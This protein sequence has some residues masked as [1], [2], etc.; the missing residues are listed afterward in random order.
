MRTHV[1]ALFFDFPY[2]LI[3]C[4][5]CQHR[6][7]DTQSLFEMDQILG[8]VL[9]RASQL[10]PQVFEFVLYAL[11]WVM[12]VLQR[13]LASISILNVARVTLLVIVNQNGWLAG[14]RLF[15]FTSLAETIAIKLV[16]LSVLVGLRFPIN[17][18][19]TFTKLYL[20][21]L[22]CCYLISQRCEWATAFFFRNFTLHTDILVI[23]KI[24]RHP[25]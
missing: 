19:A 7:Q 17:S 20:R 23:S 11:S 5:F 6:L 22:N 13:N 10:N 14:K 3:L 21:Q 1:I 18:N 15:K 9:C 25:V 24:V 4:T 8:N 2:V 12:F 16:E